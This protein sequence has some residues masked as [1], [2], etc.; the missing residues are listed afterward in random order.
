[1]LGGLDHVVLFV[2]DLPRASAFYRDVLGLPVVVDTPGFV[3]V[4]A[5]GQRLGLHPTETSGSDVG[6]GPIPYF[7][8]T[9]MEAAMQALRSRGVRVAGGI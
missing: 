4:L 6:Q 7:Q 2:N 5:G 9:D 3:G 1:M 8:V